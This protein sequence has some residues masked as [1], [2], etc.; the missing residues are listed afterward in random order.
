MISFDYSDGRSDGRRSFYN[1]AEITG[2]RA[3]GRCG[4]KTKEGRQEQVESMVDKG[5]HCSILSGLKRD[6][7]VVP[8]AKNSE[9]A[10]SHKLNQRRALEK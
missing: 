8:E 9:L 1:A 2:Q 10:S 4:P 7:L 3:G 6:N 5:V